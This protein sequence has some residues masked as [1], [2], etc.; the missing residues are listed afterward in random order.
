VQLATG[1]RLQ[2]V[3]DAVVRIAWRATLPGLYRQGRHYGRGEA[4]LH[5]KYRGEGMPASPPRE[6]LGEWKALVLRF[7]RLRTKA[8]FGNWFRRAGRKVGRL[9]GSLRHRVPYL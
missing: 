7:P 6:A 4:Y 1:A 9:Q 5:K 8:Q 3:P 2:F